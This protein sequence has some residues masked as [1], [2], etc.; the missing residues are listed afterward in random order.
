MKEIS[1]FS[2]KDIAF[3]PGG[4]HDIFQNVA[5]I[6]TTTKGSVPLDRDFG[7]S[8]TFLDSPAPV[9]QAKLRGEIVSAIEMYEP[10]AYVTGVSF[11]GDDDGRLWPVVQIGVKDEY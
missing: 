1:R 9:A 8:G 2:I 10:R 3:F 4:H 11:R 6:I 7:I 5:T